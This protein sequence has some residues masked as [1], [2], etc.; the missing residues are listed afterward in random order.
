[1]LQNLEVPKRGNLAKIRR[2]SKCIP[3]LIYQIEDYE[4][5]L[6]QLSKL[7]KVNLLRHAK[8]SVA[9][10]FRIEDKSGE[11]EEDGTSANAVPSDNEPYEGAGGPTPVESYA[12]EN[13]SSES[14]RGEDAGNLKAP[15]EANADENI[16]SS[17]PCGS[18]VQES[19]SDEEEELLAP[20]KRAKTKQIVQD[21]EDEMEDR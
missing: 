18:P 17:I 3:D 10:D 5:Y 7:T 8:R 16:G 20:R 21:S 1:M 2:E 6:I 12:D 14:E 15:V 19:E 4:K 11:Q 9:R 13:A